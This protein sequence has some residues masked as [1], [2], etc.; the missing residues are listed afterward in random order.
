MQFILHDG[1]DT[2]HDKETVSHIH[3]VTS[4][5]H[6]LSHFAVQMKIGGLLFFETD[7]KKE[8]Y[9]QP[10]ITQLQLLRNSQW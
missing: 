4:Y 7:Q 8:T 3:M 10:D 6:Y 5:S 2:T 1:V 9:S